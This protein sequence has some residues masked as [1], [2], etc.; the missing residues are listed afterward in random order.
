MTQVY[1]NKSDLIK[2]LKNKDIFHNLNDEQIEILIFFAVGARQVEI[3]S[4]M[5]LKIR[6]VSYHLTSIANRF[7]TNLSGLRLIL[8]SRLLIE[9]ILNSESM[10]SK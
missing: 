4:I 9:S 2:K 6:K 7:D 10:L 5:N 8:A 3:A 1:G